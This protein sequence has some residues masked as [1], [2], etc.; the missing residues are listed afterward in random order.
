[1][2]LSAQA[3][4]TVMPQSTPVEDDTNTSADLGAGPLTV[5]EVASTLSDARVDVSSDNMIA[6]ED[7]GLEID[8]NDDAQMY[9]SPSLG[10]PVAAES[11][12]MPDYPGQLPGQ[13][14]D[15]GS[16]MPRHSEPWN[17][18]QV[19]KGLREFLMSRH[20]SFK[21]D[22]QK[23]AI[24][25]AM[26]AE[27]DFVYIAGTGMGKSLVFELPVFLEG[28]GD[29]TIVI[30]PLV[31]LQFDLQRRVTD[32]RLL[33]SQYTRREG[34]RGKVGVM[35]VSLEVAGSLEFLEQVR[36]F[37]PRRIVIDEA[38]LLIDW[39]HFRPASSRV[40]LLGALPC[41][42]ILLSATLTKTDVE[43]FKSSFKRDL[44]VIVDRSVRPNAKYI[45]EVVRTDALFSRVIELVQLETQCQQSRDR[46]IIFSTTIQEC[47]SI[48]TMLNGEGF[49]CGLFHGRL[50][51]SEK[52]M[53]LASW[54][55]GTIRW[56]V[57]TDAFGAGIDFPS[58]RTVIIV[59]MGN[60]FRNDVQR[61]GRAG[62]DGR[63]ARCYI[64]ETE[65]KL[66]RP[67][68]GQTLTASL[69]R[70]RA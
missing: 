10:M 16:H 9:S 56:V 5:E 19:T 58:C 4:D 54:R 55:T 37:P 65:A 41:Q 44:G 31:A 6:L 3:V 14:V 67:D 43:D 18:D 21:S 17:E 38:H 46:G 62:R 50:Q 29:L 39:D 35:V 42:L 47:T 28:S 36:R 32:D 20:A 63:P 26:A 40:R 61:W 34:L 1:M 8:N 45:T 70:R 49:T 7:Y 52:E 25:E 57:A 59:H 64:V 69:L 22:R 11:H 51:Q 48:A 2:E 24:E 23:I 30:A 12:V 60:S 15:E 33:V 27:R 53:I 13:T 68:V 66:A